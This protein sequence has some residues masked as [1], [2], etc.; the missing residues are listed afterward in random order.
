MLSLARS[1][2]RI[3]ASGRIEFA[4]PGGGTEYGYMVAT[5]VFSPTPLVQDAELGRDQLTGFV[6]GFFRLGELA[7]DSISLLEPRGVE[8][9]ILDESGSAKERF[10]HFYASRLSPRVIGPEN[11]R[12]G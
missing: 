9:L 1:Q 10:L 8:I 7:N 11:L 2:K 12:A 5:P 4:L 3:T 6:V